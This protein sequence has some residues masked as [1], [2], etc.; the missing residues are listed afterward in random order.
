LQSAST[1]SE[2]SAVNVTNLAAGAST[3]LPQMELDI[4]EV[5]KGLRRQAYNIYYFRRLYI[6]CIYADLV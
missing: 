2:L 1:P 4:P 5:S 3:G 6:A